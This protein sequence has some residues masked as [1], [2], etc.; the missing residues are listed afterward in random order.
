MLGIH[1]GEFQGLAPI[2]KRV[3]DKAIDMFDVSGGKIVEPWRDG[4]NPTDFPHPPGVPDLSR[5]PIVGNSSSC[6]GMGS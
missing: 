2:G 3:E 1:L 4:D 6:I 5:T